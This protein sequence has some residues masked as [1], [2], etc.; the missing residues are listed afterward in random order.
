MRAFLSSTFEDL[1]EHRRAV[2]D[3]LERLGI[4]VS[5]MEAFGARPEEPRVA[6]FEEIDRSDIFVGIYAHRYGSIVPGDVRSITAEEFS[7]ARA[8]GKPLFCFLVARD[9]PWP[10]DM[11]EGEPGL[12][13]LAEFKRVVDDVVVRDAFRSP[14]DL[15][16]KVGT[17]VGRYVAD[18]ASRHVATPLDSL[19]MLRRRAT[20]LG[21]I[22]HVVDGVALGIATYPALMDVR[23]FPAG[24]QPQGAI[25][26]W[27]GQW[28]EIR[29]FDAVVAVGA[30][31][32]QRLYSTTFVTS[33]KGGRQEVV[34][35]SGWPPG[36]EFFGTASEEL[37]AR[38]IVQPQAHGSVLLPSIYAFARQQHQRHL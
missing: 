29:L 31:Y 24:T 2:Y 38:V 15:A 5:R 28:L 1:A 32:Q 8:A 11:I 22:E 14:E 19:P 16:M 27:P 3:A 9:Y 25:S 23:V 17:S 6:C 13:L 18:C 7:H 10:A 37:V 4:S 12:T 20:E 34:G 30:H 21:G 35:G 26:I 36:M 33:F